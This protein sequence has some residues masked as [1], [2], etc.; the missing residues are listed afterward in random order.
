MRVL[1][2]AFE[3]FDGR[4]A[5][6][7]QRWLERFLVAARDGGIAH[8]VDLAAALL[9]VDYVLLPRALARLWR[10]E[11][12]DVWILTGES[13][14]GDALRVERVAVNLL[15]AAIPDNA[16]RTRRDAP[17]VRGGPDAYLATIDARKAVRALE[18]GGVG[19][20]P[21]LSAGTYC[22]NQ[23]FYV[24]RHL[25]ATS[26]RA[27]AERSRIVFLH[28]PR[29]AISARKPAPRL[30]AAASGLVALVRSLSARPAR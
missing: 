24:A 17:V 19:A 11:R 5:N 16:G 1:V 6:R 8:R 28:V 21:S 26:R 3:P 27:G 7:S 18:S 4:A 13:G 12:P 29:L 10:S 23:A 25:A 30:E 20:A 2:T 14:R 15:D 9:P 22:C